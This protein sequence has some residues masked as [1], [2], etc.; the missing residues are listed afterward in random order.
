VD[1]A[2]KRKV[3]LGS[4]QS[5]QRVEILRGRE[6]FRQVLR[7]GKRVHG[8]YLGGCILSVDSGFNGGVPIRVGFAVSRQIK[9]AIHRNRARR[10]MREAY[11]LNKEKLLWFARKR[12]AYLSLVFLFRENENTNVRKVKL[13]DIQKDVQR[14]LEAALAIE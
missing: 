5:L 10:L 2:P 14:V 11:R 1:S 8:T 9:S 3:V 7:T 4:R 6:R 12:K 13:A